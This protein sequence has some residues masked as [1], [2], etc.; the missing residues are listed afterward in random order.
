MMQ[1]SWL[2]AN[3]GKWFKGTSTVL[4]LTLGCLAAVTAR[5]RDQ[6]LPPEQAYRYSARVEGQQLIVTWKIEQGYYLYKHKLG[7]ASADPS[8]QVGEP[9]WPVGETHTDEYFGAQQIYRGVIDVSA[10]ITVSGARPKTIPLQLKLQ[11]CADAGL[12]YPPLSWKA[13]VPLPAVASPSGGND[14]RSLFKSSRPAGGSDVLPP[15][16]AFRLSVMAQDSGAVALTWVIADGY[17]LY[18][19]RVQVVS[20][21][22]ELK[23]GSVALPGGKPKHDEYFGDTEVY[24]GV[25]EAA[26]AVE[27]AAGPA[28]KLDLSITYQG[29]ADGG[30][31]YNPITKDVSVELPAAAAASALPAALAAQNAPSLAASGPVAEQDRLAELI[32]RGNLAAVLATFFGLGVLLSFTPCVLPMI[33]ILSGIIVGQ[34]EKATPLR[35]FSLALTYVQG[36]ALTYA[37]A[38][39]TFVLAFKQAPQAFFQQPWIVILFAALFAALALA[40]FGAYNLQLPSALQTRLTHFSNQQKSGTYAGT[41]I[42]GAL[43]ALVV[44]ACVA[45]AIIA[46]LSVIS[47]TG[48]IARGAAAL[49]VTGL[50]M[51]VPLLIV[52]ASAGSLLPKVGPWM[53]AVKQL[54]GAL[55]LALAVYLLTPL[56]PEALMMLLWSILAVVC[57]F[58]IFSL[59]ARAGEPAPAPVRAGGLMVLVYGVLLLVG[60]ASGG[61]DPLRPLEALSVGQSL[62]QVAEPSGLSFQRIKTVAEL[63]AAIAAAST[64]GKPVMLDFYADWCVSCKEME[65]Y[66]FTD[67]GVRS[68]LANAVLL[69]ADVTANDAHDQALLRR[70][71]IF[72]PPTIAFFSAQGVERKNFRLVGFAP[73]ERFREHVLNAFASG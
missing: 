66:T 53:N 38:G 31:C 13:D 7:I 52:G 9:A 14:L 32:Q 67:A 8:V 18:K 55:F 37:A 39:A 48:Q 20:R 2:A 29:C 47:Q 40:M 73:A 46:A 4:A 60:A 15:D 70:F 10:P 28:Q 27:R 59:K 36:M 35:G 57:G 43:S 72:G 11:G 26:L 12:C 63:E 17:Y 61:R 16:E 50:G 68:A 58:W 33:P 41:F 22:P 3:Y 5:S 19:E 45:P 44:T 1:R 30:L 23:I 21:S 42:M 62:E 51:G 71:E 25:L 34:G 54:F 6:F 69:Q 64:A 24:Y 65:K 49:Y 56:L